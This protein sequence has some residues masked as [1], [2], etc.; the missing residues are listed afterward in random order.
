MKILHVELGRHLYGGA[1]QV[2]YL[3][4]GLARQGVRNAVA[5]HQDSGLHRWLREHPSVEDAS[6]RTAS[7]WGDIDPRWYLRLRQW[8]RSERP[9]VVHVHSRRG[10]WLSVLAARA[11]QVPVVLSRRVDNPVPVLALRFLYPRLAHVITISRGIYRVLERQG[12]P[13]GQ[14]T[15]VPSAVDTGRYRPG[16][17]C[18]TVRSELG[19]PA[20]GALVGMAAQMIPR[21]GHHVLLDAVPAVLQSQPET[22]FLIFGKGPLRESLVEE[23]RRR[24]LTSTLFYPG[25]REDMPR[26]LPCLDVLVHP[27][28]MEG[29]GVALLESAACGVPIV[30]SDVGGIPEIVRDHET[31]RLVPPGNAEAL[32]AALIGILADPVQRI[33]MGRQARERVERE[34]SIG[35]MVAGNLGVYR[36]VI[37]KTV[38]RR[39][40]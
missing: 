10:D 26:I 33:R 13:S 30:A 12:V 5:C 16:G 1:R 34:F 27:A 11:E 15:C 2:A 39:G 9:D 25:F 8:I 19:L 6:V 28:L 4:E 36:E 38:T 40:R 32:S 23:T 35:S 29:L 3:I 22:R 37:G 18:D 20:R 17:D 7:P 24:G 31:G 21:K 14:M